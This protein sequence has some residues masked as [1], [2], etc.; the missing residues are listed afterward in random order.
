MMDGIS[1]EMERILAAGN[2]APSGEN[3]QPWSFI[4]R[5]KDTIEV[6]LL[7]ERDRSA[8]GW[9]NRASYLACGAAIENIVIAA[10][11]ESYHAQA[12]LLPHHDDQELV[13]LIKLSPAMDAKPDLLVACI[14]KRITNRKPFK[15]DP[16]TAAQLTA[17]H[18]AAPGVRIIQERT[19]IET[20]GRIGSVNEEVMLANQGLHGFFFGHVNWTKDEDNVNRIGFYIKTLELPPPAQAMFKLFRHWSLMRI[21]NKIGF[22]KIVADQ[23][24]T[25]NASAAA[26]AAFR[27][28]GT[29]PID[30]IQIGRTIERFWLTATSL[31]LSLQPLTGVLF[32]KLRI[33]DGDEP[34]MFSDIERTRIL[35]SYAALDRLFEGGAKH[36]AFMCR[37]GVGDPPSA[38]ASRFPLSDVVHV[39][40]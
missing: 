7:A 5:G 23:N 27:I 30:F 3:C 28:G 15:K 22:N 29:D 13:A 32:F 17:L 8:Y 18:Q 38:H 16:L 9:G 24:G 14:D 40:R 4:V 10:S 35:E 33:V 37:I 25:V 36:I 21:F 12:N 1:P 20:I 19:A 26:M 34:E 31:G 2:Q 6:R 11:A 39:V